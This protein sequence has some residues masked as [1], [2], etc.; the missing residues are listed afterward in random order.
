MTSSPNQGAAAAPPEGGE[1]ENAKQAAKYAKQGRVDL[2]DRQV[3]LQQMNV[4]EL[5]TLV[6]EYGHNCNYWKAPPE[7]AV[8]AHEYEYA[9]LHLNYNT[10]E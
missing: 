4:D 10:D 8:L 2:G 7:G 6:K 9:P 1:G 5:V 3:D